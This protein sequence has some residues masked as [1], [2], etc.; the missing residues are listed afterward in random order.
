MDDE[1]RPQHAES[2]PFDDSEPRPLPLRTPECFGCGID[3]S[4]GLGL[5][6]FRMRDQIYA[7]FAFDERHV[8]GPG[9]AHGGAI[10]AACDEILGFTT[11]LIGAPAV[12]R[13]LSIDY[14]A[15]VPLHQTHR[16]TAKI[17]EE[18]GRAIHV[19][20]KGAH[21]DDVVFTAR[22]VYVRV[23]FEHFARFGRIATPIEELRQ[24]LATGKRR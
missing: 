10:A 19:S 2:V 11:W 3:N 17:D 5:Q 6:P 13:A 18:R 4:S 16:I 15:P 1:A 22:G 7:D 24:Q 20:V 23:S 12:T 14:L 21:G 8:G 9:L